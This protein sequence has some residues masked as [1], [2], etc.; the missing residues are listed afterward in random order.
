MKIRKISIISIVVAM[1]FM[2]TSA[3]AFAGSDD[4]KLDSSYPKNGQTNTTLENM[5]IKLKFNKELG[6]KEYEKE[7]SKCFKIVDSKGKK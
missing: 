7:N 5:S 6:S 1:M 2:M 4:F 3:F